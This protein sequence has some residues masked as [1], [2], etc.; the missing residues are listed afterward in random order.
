MQIYVF[1]LKHGIETNISLGV[2]I[3]S[4]DEIR[5]DRN[6]IPFPGLRLQRETLEHQ[7]CREQAKKQAA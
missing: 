4:T 6:M 2:N 5:T 3:S 1:K 7:N